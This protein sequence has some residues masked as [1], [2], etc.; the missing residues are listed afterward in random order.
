VTAFEDRGYSFGR[1]EILEG[2]A[3]NMPTQPE[4]LVLEAVLGNS[5]QSNCSWGSLR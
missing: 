3:E 1:P 2:I 4:D 5:S